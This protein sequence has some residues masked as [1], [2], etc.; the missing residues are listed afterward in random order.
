MH[1]ECIINVS[2]EE[3]LPIFVTRRQKLSES[4]VL[5]KCHL[6]P[7]FLFKMPT[8]GFICTFSLIIFL[9]VTLRT[10]KFRNQFTISSNYFDTRSVLIR[11]T[12]SGLLRLSEMTSELITFNHLRYHSSSTAMG[13][14][15]PTWRGTDET[16]LCLPHRTKFLGF[17][18]L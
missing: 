1:R 6:T 5:K 14:R 10:S 12:C 18:D 11:E 7:M 4:L 3:P 17:F 16:P 9:L 15:K 13:T 8:G 2:C